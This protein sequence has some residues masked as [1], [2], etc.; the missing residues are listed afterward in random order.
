MYSHS[1]IPINGVTHYFIEMGREA[2]VKAYE[3][4]IL[5]F[6]DTPLLD[7]KVNQTV[8]KAVMAKGEKESSGECS[9]ESFVFRNTFYEKST[10]EYD[11]H[12]KLWSVTATFDF[13]S[14]KIRLINSLMCDSA[15]MSC[16]DADTEYYWQPIPEQ[17]SFGSKYEAIVSGPATITSLP[18]RS[19]ITDDYLMANFE[20]YMFA[21][22][23]ASKTSICG[24]DVYMTEHNRLFFM[25]SSRLTVSPVAFPQ[26]ASSS[27]D[28]VLHVDSKFLYHEVATKQDLNALARDLV[29]KRC[30]M[31]WQSRLNM[32]LSLQRN[33]APRVVLATE[34]A[35]QKLLK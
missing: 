20:D 9:G 8:R 21:L 6:Y 30:I 25:E 19:N 34:L 16:T 31:D 5:N 10:L 32:L 33:L 13:Q 22:K 28:F 23:L 24:A 1:I 14:N 12:I 3:L 26:A 18:S 27:L 4:H 11:L 17:T 7:L 15:S 29:V 2:C 35:S